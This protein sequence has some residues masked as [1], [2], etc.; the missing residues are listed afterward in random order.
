MPVL[1]YVNYRYIQYTVYE[2]QVKV[3]PTVAKST[4]IFLATWEFF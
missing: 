1:V 3:L 4:P 2:V